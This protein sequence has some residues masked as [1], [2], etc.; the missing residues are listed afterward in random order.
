MIEPDVTVIGS[1]GPDSAG[2]GGTDE[3]PLAE[4][5]SLPTSDCSVC[6]H[7]D[8]ASIDAGLLAGTPIRT[9][10]GTHSLS[11]SSVHRHRQ[12]HLSAQA[13]TEPD[14]DERREPLTLVD[15]HGQL[16]S[17]ADR[18]ERVVELATRT[19]KAMAA[20][21]AMRELRQTL[22]VIARIQA[23]PELRK[24]ASGQEIRAR[25]DEDLGLMIAN[26]IDFVLSAAGLDAHDPM[27]ARVIVGCFER[28]DD[29]QAAHSFAGLVDTSEVT[30]HLERQALDRAARVEAEVR[31]R[32]EAEM[33]RREA[34]ARPAI[35]A[36]QTLAIEGG[37][38]WTA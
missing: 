4:P 3:A 29:P 26:I 14:P 28:V 11:R 32:V 16:T 37:P 20:V 15:V 10:A 9:V 22:E 35:E 2:P 7:P 38:V 23:D 21:A 8:A 31:R 12:N 36:R 6:R 34:Q 5:V 24:M 1:D 30:K 25:I 17:L 19:R 18:L 33:A 27:W 13:I